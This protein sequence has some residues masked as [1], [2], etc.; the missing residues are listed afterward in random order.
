MRS[1]TLTIYS[2]SAGSGKTYKLT[3]IYL[4]KLFNSRFGYRKILAVTFTNKATA[5]MKNRILDQLY[6]LASGEDTTYLNDLIKSTSKTEFQIREEAKE[7]LDAILNDFSRFSVSTIDSFFQKIIRAFARDIGLHS[8]FET[9]IDHTAFLSLAVDEMIASASE[10]EL[11]RKWLTDYAKSNISDGKNW[12]L[13]GEIT[14]LAGELFKENFKMLSATEKSKLEDKDFLVK[15]LGDMNS[16]SSSFER[17]LKSFGKK[18]Q[19]ICSEFAL[20]DEMF[21]Q[22]GRG[23]PSFIRAL[24]KGEIKS[25]N[26]SVRN[27]FSDPPKWSTGKIVAPLQEAINSGL[28]TTLKEAVIYYD[29]N[30]LNY[31]TATTIRSNI[32]ALGIL[33]DVLR[34]VRQITSVE[35]SFLLSDAG[36]MLH[37]IT[38]NDQAPFIYEKVGN[39]F[40]NFMIDEFQDT[41]I[42]QWNNFRMLIE[43]SMAEGFDNVVV[44]DIKQSI[45]RWR[46]SDWRILGNLLKNQAKNERI[47]SVPLTTNWRSRSNI[48][49]FN[50]TIF[51]IIPGQLDE[52]FQSENLPISFSELFAEAV[53]EDPGKKEGGYIKLE[54]IEGDE[55]EDWINIVLKRLPSVIENFQDNGYKASDIG[56]LV[57]N[58]KEGSVVLKAI[59]DYSN[60]CSEQKKA[61]Y[62][63]DI[64]SNESLLLSQSYVIN[65]I[66]AA[67]NVLNDKSD[68]INRARMLRL[69]LLATGRSDAEKVELINGGLDGKMKMYFPQ[70]YEDF[71]DNLLQLPLFEISESIIRFFGL[72]KLSCNVGYLTAFQDHVLN[73]SRTKSADIHSFLDWWE[74]DGKK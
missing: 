66:I 15:Y 74:S 45:Y 68:M 21:F 6:K 5:E 26:Q 38:E 22:K 67:L 39:R 20:E 29:S 11:L 10:N 8:G 33:S 2:A 37:L 46:N 57:R 7:I 53:Q 72:G 59:T 28:E 51:S 3:G 19:G 50:N 1:G 62:N 71:L 73:F 69:F 40:E 43:N 12:N 64:V 63:Y 36:E 16:I 14:R 35:N 41:S 44:G 31:K 47:K 60:S 13:K 30:I 70:E 17:E 55:N 18:C 23:I 61:I 56:V 52:E 27:I 54:F 42:L 49:K 65:F 32:F 24:S 34:H 4:A 48:I 58:N 25:P 9:E